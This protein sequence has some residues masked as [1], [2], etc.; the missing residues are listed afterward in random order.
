MYAKFFWKTVDYTSQVDSVDK[1]TR[2]FWL[3]HVILH[4]H[5]T[6]L[7]F[8]VP[9]HAPFPEH[10]LHENLDHTHNKQAGKRRWSWRSNNE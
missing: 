9:F 2:S 10:D 8:Y 4:A 3:L 7:G 1:I 5:S 6:T